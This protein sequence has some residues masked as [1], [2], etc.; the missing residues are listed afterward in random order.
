MEKFIGGRL[1]SRLKSDE[2]QEA[3]SEG[4]SEKRIGASGFSMKSG[5][6]SKERP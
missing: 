6:M 3:E 2:K 1:S 4:F 5:K